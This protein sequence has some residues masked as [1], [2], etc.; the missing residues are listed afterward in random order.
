MGMAAAIKA[1]RVLRNAET[2]IGIELMCAAQALEFLKPLHPG[3]GVARA[4]GLLREHIAP[5]AA[6]RIIATDIAAATG[7]VR[8]GNL[9]RIWTL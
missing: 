2:V 1:R 8:A 5:L 9:A 6:D 7:M 3:A 4:Y